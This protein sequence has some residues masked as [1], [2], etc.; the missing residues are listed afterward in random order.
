[1]DKIKK[2]AVC[3]SDNHNEERGHSRSPHPRA[4]SAGQAGARY[5]NRAGGG[6]GRAEVQ[7]HCLQGA[8]CLFCKKAA[9]KPW[10]LTCTWEGPVLGTSFGLRFVCLGQSLP[11]LRSRV[12]TYEMGRA[13]GGWAGKG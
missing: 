1:M 6:R 10:L 13:V 7:H 2:V 8:C 3:I 12:L 11:A 9:G 4:R 5:P